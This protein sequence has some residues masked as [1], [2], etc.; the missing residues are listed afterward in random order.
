VALAAEPAAGAEPR[1]GGE[2]IA[3]RLA[4]LLACLA[5]AFGLQAGAA[6]AAAPSPVSLGFEHGLDGF[7]TAGVGEVVP[8]VVAAGPG[9]NDVCRVVLNGDEDRSELILGG[10]ASASSDGTMHFFEG[11]QYWYSFSFEIVRMRYGQPG[12]HNLIMQFKSDGDGSPNFGLDLWDYEGR[13]GL[14]TEGNAMGGNRFL[15]PLSERTWH[16]VEIHFRASSRGRGA[17]RLFLD[18]RLVDRR[19]DVNTIVPGDDYA[20]IKSG[21]YRNGG[22]IPGKSVL[23]LDSVELG[24]QR[25]G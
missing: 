2:L 6:G 14:W 16:R 25:P 7:N 12:A 13:R 10:D 15:A 24:R 3:A 9:G 8:T 20:Y 21:L 18:R 17:Y 11:A 22:A 23:L 5:L 4:L 1:A 19:S